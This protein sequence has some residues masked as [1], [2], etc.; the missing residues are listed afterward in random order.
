MINLPIYAFITHIV[1]FFFLAA[2]ANRG[3]LRY[4]LF[5]AGAFFAVVLMSSLNLDDYH[6]YASVFR[7]INFD[8]SFIEQS[9]ILYGEYLY[10]FFNYLL[11][12]FTDDFRVVRFLL[13]FIALAIKIIFLIRWGKFYAVSFVFYISI[14][15]YPDSYLLRSTI[16]SSI[17]L[18]SIWALFDNKSWY[19]FF[20]PVFIASGFH[21]SALVAIPLWFMKN[22]KFSKQNGFLFLFVILIIG[23]VGI[24]HY[25][26]QIILSYFSV[27]IYAIDK[28]LMYSESKY[29][30]SMSIIKGSLLIYLP[31]ICAFIGYQDK[32]KKAMKHYDLT[33]VIILYS[34][35]ILLG[36]SDFL[37]LSERLFRLFAF[38]FTIAVGY[39]FYVMHEKEKI[40]LTI[41]AIIALN[42]VPYITDVGPY[43]LLD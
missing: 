30:K 6:N 28:L 22:L 24:G 21:I 38:L 2:A 36:F 43:K 20:I 7:S 23:S 34:L 4:L 25:T 18:L 29:G 26:V 3:P 16:A 17:L 15:F 42:F 1:T 14:F 39:I 12:Y 5:T 19:R 40:T 10:L 13:L 32:I 31:V 9:L 27:E 33:L 37:V 41:C 11:R 35:F 8:E